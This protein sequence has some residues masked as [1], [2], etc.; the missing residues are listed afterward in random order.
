M[1]WELND[2][3]VAMA[4]H[5]FLPV[6]EHT[7]GN[8]GYVSFELDPLIDVATKLSHSERVRRYIE[9]GRKWSAGHVNRMIKVPATP[10]GIGALEVL[11]ADGVKIN[12][13]LIFTEQQ[14]ERARDAIWLSTAGAIARHYAALQAPS[15]ET[16]SRDRTPR[17]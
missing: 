4:E 8:D 10:A 15:R 16:P 17:G 2:E 12:V 1:A 5:K 13:T 14:Y 9:L 11:A 6:W 3:L 7:R